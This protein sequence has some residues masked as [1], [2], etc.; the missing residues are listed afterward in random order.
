VD[1]LVLFNRFY[2]PDI[3]IENLEVKPTLRLSDSSE[4]LLRLRW[5]AILSRQISASLAVTGGVHNESDVLKSIMA[6][7]EAVQVVSALLQHGP[8]YLAIIEQTCGGGWRRTA[9]PRPADA[10]EHEPFELPRPAGVRAGELPAYTPQLAQ[11][12]RLKRR[13]KP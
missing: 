1:G 10:R 3:D 7:A 2:Q 8:E 4:L 13:E 12:R 11:R 5:V 6:G 9:T